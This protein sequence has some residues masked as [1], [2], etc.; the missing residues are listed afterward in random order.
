MHSS[1]F[2]DYCFVVEQ[3]RAPSKSKYGCYHGDRC[4]FLHG[5]DERLTPHD[6]NKVCRFY[7]AGYCRR[8]DDCW[9]IHADP[10]KPG[11]SSRIPPTDAEEDEHLC[12]ICYDK[13]AVYGLLGECHF[14]AWDTRFLCI[15]MFES[16]LPMAVVDSL[17]CK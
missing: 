12:S 16:L 14:D 4:K 1:S 8:G 10:A 11:S 17:N 15:C 6:R 9:F 5:K 7:T 2:P 3:T 13:P